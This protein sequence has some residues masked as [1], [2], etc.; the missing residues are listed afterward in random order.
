VLESLAFRLLLATRS[1]VSSEGEGGEGGGGGGAEL[2][3][4]LAFQARERGG[5]LVVKERV[6]IREGKGGDGKGREWTTLHLVF[7]GGVLVVVRKRGEGGGGGEGRPLAS[8]H[9][10][11]GARRVAMINPLI[12]VQ[13]EGRGGRR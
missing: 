7:R 9:V 3:S 10:R 8:G 6:V 11:F 4:S 13:S 2:A 5:G 1:R 12:C